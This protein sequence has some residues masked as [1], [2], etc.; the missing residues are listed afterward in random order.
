MF[1]G[2]GLTVRIA[3]RSALGLEL[4]AIYSLQEK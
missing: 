2:G 1:T 3:P 4:A